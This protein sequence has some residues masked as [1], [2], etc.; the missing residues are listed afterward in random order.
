MYLSGFS[1]Q[2]VCR[3]MEIILFGWVFFWKII[4]IKLLTKEL[5]R[6]NTAPQYLFKTLLEYQFTWK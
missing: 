2:K 3:C 6:K 1:F 4:S 5:Q